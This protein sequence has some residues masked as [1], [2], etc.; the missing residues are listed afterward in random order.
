MAKNYR[1]DQ[2]KD[3]EY[4]IDSRYTSKQ[5]SDSEAVLLMEARLERMKNLSDEDL[6]ITALMQLK[7]Q[8]E[9][10]LENPISDENGYF[11]K[12]LKKYIDILYKRKSDFASDINITSI[13]LSQVINKHR[14]PQKEFFRRLMIHSEVVYKDICDFDTKIWYQVYYQEKI[15]QVMADQD[16]WRAE[17]EEH[18]NVSEPARPR[19][20]K[21]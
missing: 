14:E 9:E 7:L 20:K 17:V 16:Q 13:R 1:D 18:V 21:K 10:Y 3:P 12:F 19:Y 11:L 6:A 5:E 2:D 8:M 4:G 15:C